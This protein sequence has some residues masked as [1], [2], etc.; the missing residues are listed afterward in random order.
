MARAG[1]AQKGKY[2]ADFDT[3]AFCF[4]HHNG[5]FLY[6]L[7]CCWCAA[8]KELIMAV[9]TSA[10]P[11]HTASACLWGL[12]VYCSRAYTAGAGGLLMQ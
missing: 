5:L 3:F 2:H 4:Y 1:G 10:G 7:F 6:L 12:P 9:S 8:M 11:R